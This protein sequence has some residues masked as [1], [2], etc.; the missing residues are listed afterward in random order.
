MSCGLFKIL[1][2]TFEKQIYI[3]FGTNHQRCHETIQPTKDR[4]PKYYDIRF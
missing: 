3:R 1:P 4:Y 2:K